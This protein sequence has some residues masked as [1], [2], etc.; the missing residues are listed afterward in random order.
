MS[1]VPITPGLEQAPEPDVLQAA[2]VTPLTMTD[3]E[4]FQ[5]LLAV[6]TTADA[7]PAAASA[8]VPTTTLM[9]VLL[10]SIVL[11]ICVRSCMRNC[12]LRANLWNVRQNNTP[13]LMHNMPVT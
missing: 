9:I 8:M 7:E 1:L 10:M 3:G 12:K 6:I 11:G 4:P 2:M 13:G 5:L